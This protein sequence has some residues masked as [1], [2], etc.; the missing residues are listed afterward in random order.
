MVTRRHQAALRDCDVPVYAINAAAQAT[1]LDAAKEYGIDVRMLKG[2][3]HFVMMEDVEG[4]N[5]ELRRIV[6]AI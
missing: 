3:G 1:D 4:F 5:R 2:V 6:D